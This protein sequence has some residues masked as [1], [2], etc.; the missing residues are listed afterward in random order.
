VDGYRDDARVRAV[1]IFGSFGRGDWRPDSDLDVD[2][3][4]AD[5]AEIDAERELVRLCT[6]FAPLGEQAALIIRVRKVVGC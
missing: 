6:S 5:D 3:V 2:V 4:I 1:A